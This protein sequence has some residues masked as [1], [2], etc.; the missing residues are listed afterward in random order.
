MH[1]L[2]SDVY[3]A[4]DKIFFDVNL[5]LFRDYSETGP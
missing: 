1:F 3:I 2:I 4:E 5:R